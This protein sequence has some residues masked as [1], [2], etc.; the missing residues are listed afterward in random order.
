MI[1]ADGDIRNNYNDYVNA[2]GEGTDEFSP[3]EVAKVYFGD[4]VRR[5]M[6][7]PYKNKTELEKVK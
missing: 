2:E 6:N 3:V 1:R 7:I 5:W 4:G